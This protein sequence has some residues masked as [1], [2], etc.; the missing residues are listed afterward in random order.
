MGKHVDDLRAVDMPYL[1]KP[2]PDAGLIRL[3]SHIER[4]HNK[5]LI[6]SNYTWDRF[7]KMWDEIVGEAV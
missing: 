7:L 3:F 2:L 6:P 4:I 5:G 1:G